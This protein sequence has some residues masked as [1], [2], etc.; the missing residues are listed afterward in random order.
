MWDDVIIGE[1]THIAMA[2]T[3]HEIEGSNHQ[4]SRNE[5]S[6]WISGLLCGLGMKIFKD[7][8]EGTE[9]ASMIGERR[10]LEEILNFLNAVLVKHVAQEVLVAAIQRSEKDAF[11]EGY[12]AAQKDIRKALGV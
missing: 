9:L 10:S 11:R 4:I 7:T 1:G 5:N 8:P 6:Y 3:V 2:Y 12:R